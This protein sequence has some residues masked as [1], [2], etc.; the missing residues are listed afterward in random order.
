MQVIIPFAQIQ[1]QNPNLAS[2]NF[3]ETID[4]YF[5]CISVA[6][7]SFRQHNKDLV[8][9][10][11][12]NQ[13]VNRNFAEILQKL[14]VQ[15][16]L[17]E[18]SFNPPKE[19]GDNFR[20]CFYFFDALKVLDQ[21]SFIVDPDVICLGPLQDMYSR[22]QNNISVFRP[23]FK[24]DQLINGLTPF[25]ASQIYREYSGRKSAVTPNHIG[26]EG[27]YIPFSLAPALISQVTELWQWNIERA[28]AG[29]SFLTTEEH[30]LSVLLQDSNCDSLA[31]YLS[32]IWTAK[33]YKEIEGEIKVLEELRMWHLPREKNFGFQKAFKLIFNGDNRNVEISMEN[34]KN[35]MNLRPNLIQQL[36]YWIVRFLRKSK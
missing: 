6:C 10:V 18:Y 31:P 32:R 26:G 24:E 16:I 20:G 4:K 5:K 33:S 23:L 35:L 15:I 3:A 25:Q 21:D 1:S 17:A 11:I 19:F 28:K 22:L 36:S 27:F 7:H 34:Y 2:N 30:I 14:N 29:K 13:E 8:I 12:T 9:K